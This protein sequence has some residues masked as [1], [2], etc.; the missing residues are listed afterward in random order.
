MKTKINPLKLSRA[1]MAKTVLNGCEKQEGHFYNSFIPHA[2][3]PA[4]S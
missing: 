4:L 3:P 1:R 2:K